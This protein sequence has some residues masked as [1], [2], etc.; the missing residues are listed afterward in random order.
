MQAKSYFDKLL[1][2]DASPLQQAEQEAELARLRVEAAVAKRNQVVESAPREAASYFDRMLSTRAAPLTPAPPV[3][4]PLI[5]APGKGGASNLAPDPA[6]GGTGIVKPP[7]PQA[8]ANKMIDQMLADSTKSDQ[9]KQMQEDMAARAEAAGLPPTA[10]PR[11]RLLDAINRAEKAGFKT[12]HFIGTPKEPSGDRGVS[13]DVENLVTSLKAQ[14]RATP[15]GPARDAIAR[16]RAYWEQEAAQGMSAGEWQAQT[17]EGDVLYPHEATNRQP[18]GPPLELTELRNTQDRPP[19]PEPP[20]ALAA[21]MEALQARRGKRRAVLVTPG[22][23]LPPI[24]PGYEVTR[25][26]AGTFI[27]RPDLAPDDVIR[28]VDAGTYQELL[29]IHEPKS[30]QTTAAVVARDEQGRELFAALASPKNVVR[31]AREVKRQFPKAK[32]RM[33]QPEQVLA[34]RGAPQQFAPEDLAAA[35]F[36]VLKA[37]DMLKKLTPEQFEGLVAP[38]KAKGWEVGADY[39][40]PPQAAPGQY[41]LW[42]RQLVG[43]GAPSEAPAT[44]P[45]DADYGMPP[46]T[47]LLKSE[48]VGRLA[49]GVV[50]VG[51]GMVAM[52]PAAGEIAVDSLVGKPGLAGKKLWDMLGEP[53]LA[54]YRK[55][56]E[57]ARARGYTDGRA[58]LADPEVAQHFAAAF[59]PMVGPMASHAIDRARSGD[60]A[61]A[62]GE[63]IMIAAPM[64]LHG[65][66]GKFKGSKVAKE[67]AKDAETI[68]SD[69]GQVREGR[70]EGQPEVQP[71]AVEGSGDLQREAPKRAGEQQVAR[72]EGKVT[73]EPPAKPIAKATEAEPAPPLNEREAAAAESEAARV[74]AAQGEFDVLGPED[75]GIPK[76]GGPLKPGEKLG[77]REIKP[78]YRETVEMFGPEYMK[79]GLGE[80]QTVAMQGVEAAE[81][82][83]EALPKPEQLSQ[84]F[85]AGTNNA[86]MVFTDANQRDLFKLGSITKKSERGGG[87]QGVSFA[88]AAVGKAADLKASLAERMGIP[89]SEVA[90]LARQVGMDVRAQMRGVKHLE[91]RQLVDNVGRAKAPEPQPV[92]AALEPAATLPKAGGETPKALAAREAAAKLEALGPEPHKPSPEKRFFG[93]RGREGAD[94]AVV[95]RYDAEVK[96]H[97]AWRRKYGILKKAEVGTSNAAFYERQAA[98]AEPPK[99]PLTEAPAKPKPIAPEGFGRANKLVKMDEAAQLWEEFKENQKKKR[100]SGGLD[101]EDI[102]KLVKIGA[103]YV[104][105]GARELGA[106]TKH[107]VD[108]VGEEARAWAPLIHERAVRFVDSGELRDLTGAKNAIVEAERAL[109]GMA[110][111]EKQMYA[112]GGESFLEAKRRVDS[113]P[114]YAPTLAAAVAER[115]RPLDVVETY[116]LGHDRMKIKNAIRAKEA[117]IAELIEAGKDPAEA[118]LALAAL[119]DA[120]NVNDQALVKGGREQSA[121]FNAR[122]MIERDDYELLPVLNRV[123][124]NSGKAEVAPELRAEL[125]DLTDKFAAAEAKLEAQGDRMKALEAELA[126]KRIAKDAERT[127]RKAKRA[128]TKAE[129]DTEFAALKVQFAEARKEAGRAQA[130]GF[131]S[132]DPEGKLTALVGKMAFNRFKAGVTTVEGIVDGIYSE[133]SDQLQ[134]LNKDDVRD[135]ISGYGRD[136]KR[137]TVNEARREYNKL[138]SEM[139]QMAGD[140][141]PQEKAQ[142]TQLQNRINVMR[143]Q[144]ASGHFEQPQKPPRVQSSEVARLVVERNRLRYEIDRRVAQQKRTHPLN[145]ATSAQQSVMLGNLVGIAQ[146]IVS[147]TG[148]NISATPQM[149]PAVLLD[150]LQGTRTKQRVNT[151]LGPVELAKAIGKGLANVPKEAKE[152]AKH[153]LSEKQA[154]E[155]EVPHEMNSGNKTLDKAVAAVSRSRSIADLPNWEVGM[156]IARRESSKAVAKTEALRGET[157]K[158][159]VS[160]RAK[161]I[162]D[163]MSLAEHLDIAMDAAAAIAKTE[164]TQEARVRTFKQDNF[165]SDLVRSAITDKSGKEIPSRRFVV[166]FIQPFEKAMS[167]YIKAGFDLSGP[168]VFTGLARAS[169]NLAR[170]ERFG[171]DVMKLRESQRKANLAFS[172]GVTGGT[173]GLLLGYTLANLGVIG[174]PKDEENKMKGRAASLHFGDKSFDIG[175]M[176]PFAVPVA[177][178]AGIY[179]DQ[180][181]GAKHAFVRSMTQAPFVRGGRQLYNWTQAAEAKGAERVGTIAGQIVSSR[182]IPGF[183]RDVARLADAGKDREQKGFMGPIKGS[184]PGLRQTLPERRVGT[185]DLRRKAIDALR[186]DPKD[187]KILD[188]AITAGKLRSQDRAEIIAESKLKPLQVEFKHKPLEEKLKAYRGYDQAQQDETRQLLVDSWAEATGA[189]RRSPKTGKMGERRTP[190]APAALLERLRR[191]YAAELPQ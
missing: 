124:V 123:R 144:L 33:E 64:A 9:W 177:I 190:S 109:R 13:R 41:P 140:L 101:T 122:K 97:N 169:I 150:A 94:P 174:D 48:K 31:Q 188:D 112:A 146:D 157:A 137:R 139:R 128:E 73:A 59:T 125:K 127:T 67:V 23:Q 3:K 95:A 66:R 79:R 175:W 152:I 116:A 159:D 148:G 17:G 163:N 129:L 2:S 130:S 100:G 30:P 180:A 60:I 178:G 151:V 111:V 5:G 46:E 131:A 107:L 1:G 91:T 104:E 22:E 153:G 149:I 154:R 4:T 118:N 158:G 50:D 156:E 176:G 108:L 35:H 75:F 119:E 14:E 55:A 189:A 25:T 34:G 20:E 173:G 84:N 141:S 77:M 98:A 155:Q 43:K 12:P 16:Q 80:E 160:K 36:E 88:P 181:E 26:S 37:G 133:L 49:S 57:L 18:V 134:G 135:A 15:A 8:Q 171:G 53:Q 170:P 45:S 81:P 47:R 132:I 29:G 179:Y 102:T 44:P 87:E 19:V 58:A 74:K 52:I 85:R 89:E 164:A 10:D 71:G 39:V 99:A 78:T 147:T 121:A 62:I 183:V 182:T 70:T 28:S 93:A 65:V 63:G 105:G 42:E 117:E 120:W 83:T 126:V 56:Q 172:R 136:P 82:K 167:N 166:R 187:T 68:R 72:E 76:G 92:G 186:K 90:S 110:P 162:Y 106:F 51:K 138:L 61:G 114:T 143:E 96:A 40:K 6:T 165:F 191:E 86:T 32:V 168:G 185:G 145:V 113:D 103:A 21:Q 38:L 142:R 69:A 54:E 11:T 27:H 24:P 7:N 184:I 161:E 115:V